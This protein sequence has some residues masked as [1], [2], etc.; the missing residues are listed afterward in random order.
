M[1]DDARAELKERDNDCE[2]LQVQLTA[3]R[4]VIEAACHYVVMCDNTESVDSPKVHVALRRLRDAVREYQ[5]KVKGK[6]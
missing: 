4:Q 5:E 3:Q 2:R 1:Y 6:T